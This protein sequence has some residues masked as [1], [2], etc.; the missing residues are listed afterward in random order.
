MTTLLEQLKRL[1]FSPQ[2]VKKLSDWPPSLVEDYLNIADNLKTIAEFV[3]ALE[4]RITAL[5]P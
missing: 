4:E 2:E 1:D 3:D 5:E